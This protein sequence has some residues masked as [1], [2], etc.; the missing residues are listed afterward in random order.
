MILFTKIPPLNIYSKWQNY[1][2]ELSTGHELH[3]FDI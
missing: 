1:A 2:P 3:S